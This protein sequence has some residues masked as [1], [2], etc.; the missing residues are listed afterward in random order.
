MSLTV[1]RGRL[2]CGVF[3][4]QVR[5]EWKGDGVQEDRSLVIIFQENGDF[6]FDGVEVHCI[7]DL[8][9]GQNVT[10]LW[11]KKYRLKSVIYFAEPL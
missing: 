10:L 5:C 6:R 8:R 9:V 11:L 2:V 4:C 7:K 1:S 3:K